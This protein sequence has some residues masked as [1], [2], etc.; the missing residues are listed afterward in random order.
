MSDE[1]QT[2]NTILYMVCTYYGIEPDDVKGKNRSRN[3]VIARQ[4]YSN[5]ARVYTRSTW[6]LIGSIINRDHSTIIYSYGQVKSLATFDKKT[7]YDLRSIVQLNP[8]LNNILCYT[9]NHYLVEQ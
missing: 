5:L 4:M 8:E 6:K 2:L 1:K 3:L 9:Q 7:A